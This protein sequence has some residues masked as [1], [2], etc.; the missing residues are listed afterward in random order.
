VRLEACSNHYG[1]DARWEIASHDFEAWARK[2]GY[3]NGTSRVD[4]AAALRNPHVPP[5]ISEGRARRAGE[6]L[7]ADRGAL[8]VAAFVALL[9]DHGDG[10]PVWT[11]RDA[12]TDEERYFTLCAHSAPVHRTTASLVAALPDR[13]RATSP[14]WVS[15]GTPCTGIFLPVYFGGT[16]PASLARRADNEREPSAWWR[17]Q[18]LDAAVARDPERATPRVREAWAPLERAI[19]EERSEVERAARGPD[20]SRVLSD[21]MERTTQQALDLATALARQLGA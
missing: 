14:L 21:F 20:A 13:R 17:F 18:R 10:G 8:D 7:A 9:R 3:W 12:G 19:E 5:H 11:A 1:L 6:R 2:D 15:F 4:V 16:L